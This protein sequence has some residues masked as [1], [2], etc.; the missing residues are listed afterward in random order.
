MGDIGIKVSLPGYDVRGCPDYKLMVNSAW[1]ALKIFSIG[2]V[3]I[4]N[5]SN[6]QDI[7][8]HNL[9]FYPLFL[10]WDVVSSKGYPTN[11]TYQFVHVNKSKLKW[12]GD[13]VWGTNPIII[14]YIICANNLEKLYIS[15]ISN[16][17][18]VPS[19][20][21]NA[22]FGL[23]ASLDNKNI[24]SADIRDYSMHSKCLNFLVHK[25]IYGT[26]QNT[27]IGGPFY[28]IDL[29]IPHN[30][31]YSPLT[32]LYLKITW[33]GESWYVNKNASQDMKYVITASNITFQQ[34]TIT[35]TSDYS[36]YIFKDYLVI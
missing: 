32:M 19:Q 10:I 1:P 22:N 16:I 21:D 14:S 17:I 6:D 27:P 33:G 2:T 7:V 15:T 3:T 34:L 11:F 28:M 18:N 13:A 5:P 26:N 20:T 29:A 24:D 30:L 12:K 36:C 23:K 31:G 25:S 9:N 4:N 8:T 35:P